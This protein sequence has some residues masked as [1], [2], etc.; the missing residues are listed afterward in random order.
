[1][2]D[3]DTP[4]EEEAQQEKIEEAEEQRTEDM[5]DGFVEGYPSPTGDERPS[6]FQIFNKVI[7]K[8]D[9]SKVANLT[10]EE[11]GGSKLA[12]R[13]YQTLANFQDFLG[14]D[15]VASY[16]RAKS[17]I[18]LA[19]SLSRGGFF[20]NLAVTQKK[21]RVKKEGKVNWNDKKKF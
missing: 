2:V 20:M 4:T 16:L 10:N 17:E 1:M 8:I 5:E 3:E 9:T 21:E 13:D 6:H 14:R 19:T 11:L 15:R 18:A 12:V 7:D